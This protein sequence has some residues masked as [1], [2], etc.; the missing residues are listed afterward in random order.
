MNE[1]INFCFKVGGKQFTTVSKFGETWPDDKNISDI[2]FDKAYLKLD[3][4]F[5]LYSSFLI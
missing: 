5:L 2:T 4:N 3:I 1:L